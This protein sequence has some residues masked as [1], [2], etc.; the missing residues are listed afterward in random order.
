MTAQF[1]VAAECGSGKNAIE[2]LQ[3]SRLHDE[4]GEQGRQYERDQRRQGLK[5]GVGLKKFL[6]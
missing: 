6:N 2:D 5:P 4:I 1:L 3:K